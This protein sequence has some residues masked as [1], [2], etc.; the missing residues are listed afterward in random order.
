MI[1]NY[2]TIAWRNLLRRKT[3]SFI[4]IAGLAIGIAACIIIF[5]Y[6]HHE[7]SFDQYNTKVD[8]IIR[9]AA[10][11]HAPESD[12]VMATAPK[13]LADVLKRGY[14]EVEATV[15]LE[16]MHQVVKFNN[17]SYRE[18]AFYGADSSV[19]SVFSFDFL[20]GT[21]VTAL[22][23]PHSIV[24]TKTIAEKYFGKEPAL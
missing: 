7:L 9:I 13:P 1:K 14:P 12:I 17:E 11:V 15:R 23:N 24:L 21:P 6:V 10:T 3:F 5:L 18:D 22:Q 19:F 4:N 2:L 8:R 20:E 16:Q